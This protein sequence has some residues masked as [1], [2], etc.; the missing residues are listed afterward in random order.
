[1]VLY[2]MDLK[3]SFSVPALHVKGQWKKMHPA[4]FVQCCV[5]VTESCWCVCVFSSFLFA[6]VTVPR[7]QH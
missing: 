4:A 6:V 5:S 7:N 1:M 2:F 3:V